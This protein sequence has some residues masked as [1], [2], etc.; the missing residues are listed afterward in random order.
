MIL[1]DYSK[2]KKLSSISIL[3]WNQKKKQMLTYLVIS[4]EYNI[5]VIHAADQQRDDGQKN[6]LV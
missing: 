5:N 1:L 6:K 3:Q 2:S 4:Y